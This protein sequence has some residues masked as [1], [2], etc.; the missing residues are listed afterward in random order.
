MGYYKQLEVSA[1][2]DVDRMVAWYQSS[3]KHLPP[4]LHKWLLLRDERVWGAIH[5]WENQANDTQAAEVPV[6]APKPATEH[7]ALQAPQI[8]RKQAL[9]LE[10]NQPVMS[11]T[12]LGYNT[13]LGV[14]L[15]LSAVL[16]AS[17]ITFVVVS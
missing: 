6:R 16:V 2:A 12:R 15:F 14:S 3:G 5:A 10:R 1:Q 11:M 4:Y 8:T 13:V 7:V 17:V 9:W